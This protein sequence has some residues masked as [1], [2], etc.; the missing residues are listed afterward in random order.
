MLQDD[1]CNIVTWLGTFQR[2]RDDPSQ[3]ETPS[4]HLQNNYSVIQ[5]IDADSLV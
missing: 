4:K 2:R 5:V 1:S 3:R